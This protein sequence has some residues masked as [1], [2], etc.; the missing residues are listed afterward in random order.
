MLAKSRVRGVDALKDRL[1]KAGDRLDFEMAAA[2]EQAALIMQRS[3]VPR[4]PVKTGA[5]RDA[6]ADS[7]AIGQSRKYK[8]GWVFGLITKALRGR[9]YKA[10]WLEYGTKGY[11]SGERRVYLRRNAKGELVEA[12]V[13]IKRD[14]PARPARPFFRPGVEAALVEIKELWRKAMER[15]TQKTR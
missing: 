3:V 4:V 11:R 5:T 7:A 13:K 12:K 1:T 10:R 8:G 15:A 6:F 14:I 9:G 2:N